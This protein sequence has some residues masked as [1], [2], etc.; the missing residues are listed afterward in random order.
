M[1][2]ADKEEEDEVLVFELL[3]LKAEDND[4]NDTMR[5]MTIAF[6]LYVRLG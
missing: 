5:T 6:C 1:C 2:R 3:M 4:T